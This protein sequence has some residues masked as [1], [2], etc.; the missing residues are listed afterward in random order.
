M[1][2]N[3]FVRNCGFLSWDRRLSRLVNAIYELYSRTLIGKKT[4]YGYPKREK[5]EWIKD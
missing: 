1:A 5:K 4:M 2:D 3:I